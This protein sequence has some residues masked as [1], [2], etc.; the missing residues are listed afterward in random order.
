MPLGD[1]KAKK[2]TKEINNELGYILDA[3]SSIGDKLVAS[4]ED[5]VDSADAL[6]SGVEII[7]KTMQRGLAANLKAVV[8]S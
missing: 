5:A 7:G 1:G 2:E 4:F 8:K 6:N 3:V